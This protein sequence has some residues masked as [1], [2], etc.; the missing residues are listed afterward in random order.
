MGGMG[1]QYVPTLILSLGYCRC[2]VFMSSGVSSL[3]SSFPLT[4]QRH[5]E[6]WNAPISKWVSEFVCEYG[7]LWWIDSLFR[8]YSCLMAGNSQGT[9]WPRAWKISYWRWMKTV[10]WSFFTALIFFIVVNCLLWK[11][12]STFSQVMSLGR[13][14]GKAQYLCWS[15]LWH[16]NFSGEGNL[17]LFFCCRHTV[18]GEIRLVKAKKNHVILVS[19]CYNV[20]Y[21]RD[22]SQWCMCTCKECKFISGK[23]RNILFLV[24]AQF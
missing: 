7:V 4:V 21:C 23:C 18:T 20:K 22:H 19:K 15:L 2:G 6:R 3:Y 11:C 13:H 12:V 17:R 8:M 14:A 10:L 5:A 1:A 9:P 16:F 24:L